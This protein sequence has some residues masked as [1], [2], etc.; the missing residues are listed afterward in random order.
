MIVMLTVIVNQSHK[1][2]RY[3]HRENYVNFLCKFFM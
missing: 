3:L 2:S 1:I